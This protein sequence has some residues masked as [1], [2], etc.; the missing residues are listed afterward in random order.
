MDQNHAELTFESVLEKANDI[1]G[2][3][4]GLRE[5]NGSTLK[6]GIDYVK[7]ALTAWCCRVNK[8]NLKQTGFTGLSVPPI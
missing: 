2:K 4:G 7:V 1:L 6:I 8:E 5:S 3:A